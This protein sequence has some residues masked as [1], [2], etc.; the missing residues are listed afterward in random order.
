MQAALTRMDSAAAKFRGLRADVKRLTHTEVIHEDEVETGAIA[1][2]RQNAKDLRM[3]IDLKTPNPRTVWFSGSKAQVYYPKI[4][5]VQEYGLGKANAM[6]DQFL[7]LG[8]GS[9][10]KELQAGYTMQPGGAETVAGQSATR[11]VL[12]PKEQRMRALFP[13]IELW[14]SDDGIAIQQKLYEP[15]GDFITATYT[16]VQQVN[17]T[18]ADVKP[19]A[20]KD[21][22]F[23]AIK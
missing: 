9:T 10:S 14:L 18:D 6:K 21:A 20:P 13:K 8:F 23:E 1:V 4:N 5:T 3:R 11:I 16:N 19:D 22:K 15:G 12:V 2:R 7:A 17:V